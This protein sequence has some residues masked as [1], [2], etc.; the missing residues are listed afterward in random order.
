MRILVVSDVHADFHKD[1]E[2]FTSKLTEADL[3]L[4]AGDLSEMRDSSY[5]EMVR[6]LSNKFSYV[7]HVPGN[8]E[9]YGK[10]MDWVEKMGS[11]MEALYPNYYFVNRRVVEI[12]GIRV[13]G[14]TTW[15]PYHENIDKNYMWLNDFDQI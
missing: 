15:F 12:D 3:L 9:Y 1:V 2:I 6:L 8:H 11:A 13:A 5:E 7:I 4:V 10:D 14:A